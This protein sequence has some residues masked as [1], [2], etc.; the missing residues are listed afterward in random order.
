MLICMGGLEIGAVSNFLGL[1]VDRGLISAAL[2][3]RP[4]EAV[5][6]SRSAY[7][8]FKTKGRYV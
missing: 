6:E 2:Q 5:Q 4:G 3:R 8:L 7:I 1:R